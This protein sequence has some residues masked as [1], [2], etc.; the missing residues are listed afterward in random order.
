MGKKL[1]LLWK[2]AVNHDYRS[3]IIEEIMHW[4]L[5]KTYDKRRMSHAQYLVRIDQSETLAAF[6]E[7]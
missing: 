7:H 3:E 6:N 5:P 1:R 4:K 2:I